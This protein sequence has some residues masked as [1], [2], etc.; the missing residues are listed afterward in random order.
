MSGYHYPGERGRRGDKV[1]G[2]GKIDGLLNREKIDRQIDRER[3]TKSEGGGGG[4][5]DGER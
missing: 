3:K 4:V 1:K 5:G 2:G